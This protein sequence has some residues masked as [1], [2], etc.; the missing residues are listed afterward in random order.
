MASI[1]APVSGAPF[2]S[3]REMTHL[4]DARTGA[5]TRANAE[6]VA[7]W[8][9]FA[10]LLDDR[11]IRWRFAFNHW[12]GHVD[13]RRVATE[14]SFYDAIRSAKEP[15]TAAEQSVA[16]IRQILASRNGRGTPAS[17]SWD[18]DVDKNSAVRRRRD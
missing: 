4:V 2:H 1:H 7:E 10:A 14:P 16:T 13:R 9:W 8:R 18:V 12:I 15:N 5:T 11:R 17:R 3:V 6:D